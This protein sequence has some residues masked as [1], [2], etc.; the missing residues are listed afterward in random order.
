MINSKES[1]QNARPPYRSGCVSE[2]LF[3]FPYNTLSSEI[4]LLILKASCL[5]YV[6]FIYRSRKIFFLNLHL[7]NI[8]YSNNLEL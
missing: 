3:N 7:E 6:Y 5:T 2:L 1:S 8:L 4:E